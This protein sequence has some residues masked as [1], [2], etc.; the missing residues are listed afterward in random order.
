MSTPSPVRGVAAEDDVP[1]LLAAEGEAVRLEGVGHEA[2]ADRGLDDGDPLAAR[3]WRSPR[4]LMTVTT[5]AAPGSSPRAEQVGGEER[6]QLVAVDDAAFVV[7][8]E[9]PVGVAVEGEPEIGAAPDDGRSQVLGMGGSAEAVDVGPVGIGFDGGDTRPARGEHAGGDHARR[10]VAAVE[11][12]VQA[13]ERRRRDR[14]HQVGGVLGEPAVVGD[15]A[16]EPV[17]RRH[18]PAAASAAALLA[19]PARLPRPPLLWTLYTISRTY[20]HILL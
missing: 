5:T 17:A 6:D 12:H 16:A 2:V 13:R 15:E 20:L 1:R 9:R 19:P 3:A 14:R 7:G 8:G 10:P 18:G 4:L 11:H